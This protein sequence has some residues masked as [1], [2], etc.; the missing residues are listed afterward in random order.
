MLVYE[1][2]DAKAH[3]DTLLKEMEAGEID[4]IDYQ[5]QLGHIDAHL[6]RAWNTRNMTSPYAEKAREKVSR[7]PT[8]IEPRF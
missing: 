2:D 4:E 5:V 8:D 6:N 1:L 3:L 7:F